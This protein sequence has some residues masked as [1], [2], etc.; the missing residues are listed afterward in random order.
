MT[1]TTPRHSNSCS[2]VARNG[3]SEPTHRNPRALPL[4]QQLRRP[5]AGATS[6]V[7]LRAETVCH[8]AEVP[9]EAPLLSK[10]PAWAVLRSGQ[11]LISSV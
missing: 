8:R 3:V 10:R 6:G 4:A 2:L 11:P 7:S 5:Q 9:V 1:R